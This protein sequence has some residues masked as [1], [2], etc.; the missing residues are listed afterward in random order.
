MM[1]FSMMGSNFSSLVM[2]PAG[3]RAG[4]AAALYGAVT[5]MSGAVLGSLIGQ[6]FDGTVVPLIAGFLAMG[7]GAL[8][9]I[10]WTEKGRLFGVG[11]PAIVKADAET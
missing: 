7:V 6:M 9:M 10:A 3:E 5:S 1:L 8:A 11:E 2:E 4:T